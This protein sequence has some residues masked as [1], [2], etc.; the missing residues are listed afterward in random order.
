MKLFSLRLTTL[1]SK[2]YA[3]VFASFV[4]RV[5][6]FFAL[7]N[8]ASN[9]APD[10]GEY[11]NL[12][13]WVSQGKPISEYPL[14]GPNLYYSARS[15]ILPSV[16]FDRLGLNSLDSIRVTSSI[17]GLLISILIAGIII[18]VSKN[19]TKAFFEKNQNLALIL[20][21]IF[22]FL[23]SHFIWSTLGLRESSV[24]FWTILTL[25]M[26]HSVIYL[27]EKRLLVG[28]IYLIGIVMVFSSR[29]QV[30]LV[31]GTTLGIYFL[32]KIKIKE[33]RFLVVTT[34]I[35]ILVGSA[36]SSASPTA[37]PTAG[38][39][40][41]AIQYLFVQAENLN[42]HHE[43]NQVGAESVI[44]TISCPIPGVS[45]VADLLCL[46][47]RTPYSASTFMFRPIIG[48]D[49]TSRSSLIAAV[50][51]I[52]WLGVLLF[53]FIAFMSNRRLAFAHTIIPS[54]LFMS[55][56]IVTA[57]AYEGNMGTAFRHKSL[58]LWVVILL[59][60]STIVATQQRKA[61]REGISGSSQE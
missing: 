47:W 57:G 28:I 58:I 15:I 4:V 48:V 3:I 39:A 6:A 17:Y 21:L 61:E 1:K 55:I 49:V 30:G 8:T 53:V 46:V 41:K 23:P 12:V 5:V 50:E 43:A 60:A 52:F 40:L 35:G 29:P 16:L 37:S 34:I 19:N 36:L 59:L 38:F 45:S 14:F 32:F 56:Y 22:T 33:A 31:L 24:E 27:K 2:L 10:E 13:G 9:F 25:I 18:K 54:R 7:P 20:F 11:A 42:T 44:S 26:A 51:N